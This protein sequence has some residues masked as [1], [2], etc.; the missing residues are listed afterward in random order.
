MRFAWALFAALL[1]V[2]IPLAASC[3]WLHVY[4]GVDHSRYLPIISDSLDYWHEIVN[5]AQAPCDTGYYGYQETHAPL[6]GWGGHAPWTILA[7][8][9]LM[10][11]AGAVPSVVLDLNAGYLAAGVLAYLL[12]TR[13]DGARMGLVVALC[14]VFAP[15]QLGLA[16][17]FPD[18]LNIALACV[19]AGLLAQALDKDADRTAFWLLLGC[20]AV[21]VLLHKS[22]ITLFPL[23]VAI[24]YLKHRR[25]WWRYFLVGTAVMLV[26][27]AANTFLTAPYPFKESFQAYGIR[28]LLS[29]KFSKALHLLQYNATSL[30]HYTREILYGNL[31]GLTMLAVSFAGLGAAVWKRRWSEAALWAYVPFTVVAYI[32]GH[33]FNGMIAIRHLAPVFLIPLLCLGLRRSKGLFLFF[34]AA[35]ILLYPAF[36]SAFRQLVHV[37]YA[38]A[39]TQQ[40]VDALRP[41]LA[42]LLERTPGASPWCHTVASEEYYPELLALPPGL[43]FNYVRPEDPSLKAPL[44]S[45]YLLV[46]HPERF[47]PLFRTPPRLL[48]KTPDMAVYEN[49]DSLC[50]VTGPATG[51]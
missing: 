42:G 28:E 6:G 22:W 30:F 8:A 5:M 23:F 11:W 15:I 10:K 48:L 45:R 13:A 19:V 33:L 35:N 26:C 47:L 16:W 41:V 21:M 24:T 44:K 14:A 12:L 27:W 51:R 43:A 32:F 3:L 4:W 37:E 2:A 46:K 39:G 7:Y 38:S 17:L 25:C 18:S 31:I 50:P 40:T 1:A 34:L 36:L 49:R 29:G 20:C 9:W